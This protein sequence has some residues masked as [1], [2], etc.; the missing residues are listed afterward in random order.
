MAFLPATFVSTLFGMN[1]KEVGQAFDQVD[2]FGSSIRL[3]RTR[4]R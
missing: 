3:V 2:Q 4:V 1:L